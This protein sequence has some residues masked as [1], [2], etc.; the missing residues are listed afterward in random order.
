MGID[1]TAFS[2]VTLLDGA[3]QKL[4]DFMTWKQPQKLGLMAISLLLWLYGGISCLF[5]F[6]LKRLLLLFRIAEIVARTDEDRKLAWFRK[7]DEMREFC[8]ID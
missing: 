6:L 2:F 1:C 5:F 3:K 8:E 7:C 4:D